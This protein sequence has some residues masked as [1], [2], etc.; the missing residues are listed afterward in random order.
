MF[1]T[2]KSAFKS[3]SD[4][5][6]ALN[7]LLEDPPFKSSNK[8]LKQETFMMVMKTFTK[9]KGSELPKLIEKLGE[10]KA[11]DMLKYW[12]KA[13]E[14]VHKG[15]Q[16]VIDAISFPLCLNY[17]NATTEVFGSI[18]VARTGFER[19]DLYE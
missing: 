8:A 18:G 7:S 6:E 11:I 19:G 4:S 9:M 12:Y 17:L 1:D 14:L 2:K 5:V 10:D 13:F 16:D 15:N 3:A